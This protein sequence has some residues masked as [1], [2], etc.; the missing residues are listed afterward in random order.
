M[1]SGRAKS[2]V[3]R[4]DNVLGWIVK[5]A[6]TATRRPMAFADASGFADARAFLD[7]RRRTA[8]RRRGR[9]N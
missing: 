2:R 6:D 9:G 4:L 8:D 1:C 5:V 3:R 7:G